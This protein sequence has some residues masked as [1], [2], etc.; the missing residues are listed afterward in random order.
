MNKDFWESRYANNNTGWDL[1]QPS[2]PLVEFIDQL[3]SKD[4]KILIPGCGNAYEAEYLIQKDFTNV[5][6]I[7]LVEQPLESL[8]KRV[9]DSN[10]LHIHCEDLFNHEGK[11][12]LILE[13]TIFCAI[14]PSRRSDYAKKIAQLLVDNGIYAGVLFDRDFEGGPPFGGSREEYRALFTPH[15]KKLSLED[16]ANSIEPRSGS[17]VFVQF[18][19]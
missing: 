13:Q 2:T 11:Y 4:L 3:P 17:E 1:G 18:I 16:C 19:K 7:D 5:H 8:K 15:F 12:D 14:D 10:S 6:V 9:G